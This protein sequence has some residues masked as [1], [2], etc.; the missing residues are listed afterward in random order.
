M[1][2]LIAVISNKDNKRL[3]EKLIEERYL[4]TKLASTGGFLK[5]GNTTLLIGV[6]DEYVDNVIDIISVTCKSRKKMYTPIA[7]LPETGETFIPYSREVKVGGATIF[8]IDIEKQMK[9]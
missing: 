8:V 9:V 7:P 6:S 3:V 4:V 1:K 5:E 2:L